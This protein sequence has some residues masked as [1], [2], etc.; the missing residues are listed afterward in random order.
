MLV[1]NT[2]IINPDLKTPQVAMEFLIL[3]GRLIG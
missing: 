3:R 2:P 1:T